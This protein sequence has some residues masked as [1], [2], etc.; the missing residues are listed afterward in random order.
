M[1][2]LMWWSRTMPKW[3]DIKGYFKYMFGKG[4]L[5]RNLRKP[6]K[7]FFRKDFHPWDHQNQGL[8]DMWKKKYYQAKHDRG[9][10]AYQQNKSAA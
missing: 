10:E 6:Y 5:M 8:V 9:S 3:R 4:G 2:L 1:V 7:D